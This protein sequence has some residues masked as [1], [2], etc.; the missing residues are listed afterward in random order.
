MI[1]REIVSKVAK[2]TNM[3]RSEV[4]AVIDATLDAIADSLINGETVVFRNFGTF[5]VEKSRAQKGF[6][7]RKGVAINIP[8]KYRPKF[9]FSKELSN[10]INI[11]NMSRELGII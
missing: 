6:D 2:Q 3:L 7:F 11:A 1:K 5:K 9:H 8:G 4:E 10:E